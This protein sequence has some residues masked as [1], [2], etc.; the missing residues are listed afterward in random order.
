MLYTIEGSWQIF[1]QFL[2]VRPFD[3][4]M[5]ATWLC[6]TKSMSSTLYESGRIRLPGWHMQDLGMSQLCK[7]ISA[8]MC[9][10]RRTHC[11][12]ARICFASQYKLPGMLFLLWDCDLPFD[13]PTGLCNSIEQGTWLPLS[14][15]CYRILSIVDGHLILTI[16]GLT[17]Y[18]YFWPQGTWDLVT[19]QKQHRIFLEEC[20]SA[21]FLN[22]SSEEIFA[23]YQ[24]L[25]QTILDTALLLKGLEWA[26]LLLIAS[27]HNMSKLRNPRSLDCFAM[28]WVH[29]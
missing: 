20:Y 9:I 15:P 27:Q 19:L 29:N 26:F 28:L 10:L 16:V 12:L 11:C 21:C 17:E 5:I 24:C 23:A 7:A 25:L 18:H 14:V 13:E 3:T 4:R 1:H 22:S 6:H 8:E 2:T